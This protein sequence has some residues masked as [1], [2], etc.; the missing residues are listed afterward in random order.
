[1]QNQQKKIFYR[2]RATWRGRKKAH[3]HIR[4]V[5]K[6]FSNPLMMGIK[7]TKNFT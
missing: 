5:Q 7:K 4:G 2:G 1:M 6:N 3:Q